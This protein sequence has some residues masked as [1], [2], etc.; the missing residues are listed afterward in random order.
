MTDAE[1]T[2]VAET[3]LVWLPKKV[4][5][6]RHVVTIRILRPNRKQSPLVDYVV[7]SEFWGGC[8][9]LSGLNDIQALGS[10]LLFIENAMLS[11]MH[12][13]DI[14]LAGGIRFDPEKHAAVFGRSQREDRTAHVA[15]GL[16]KE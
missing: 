3:R 12:V 8:I 16:L 10:C 15:A 5:G 14:E 7:D 4:G 11:W 13:F 9:E 6:Q 2:L 1:F